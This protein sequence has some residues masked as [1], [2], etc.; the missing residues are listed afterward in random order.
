MAHKENGHGATFVCP[1]TPEKTMNLAALLFVD[2]TDIIHI[3]MD[4]RE[5]IQE[6]HAAL[7]ASVDSWNNLLIA[8]GGALHPDKCFFYLMSYRFSRIKGEWVYENH[9]E[10][11]ELSISITMPDGTS[12]FIEQYPVAHAETMLG[13]KTCPLGNCVNQCNCVNE[14]NQIGHGAAV[15]MCICHRRVKLQCWPSGPVPC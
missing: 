14:K 8:T 15:C 2:D 11:E 9:V 6:V 12:Q 5:S 7:A 3:N 1:F 10:D 13:V 4:R